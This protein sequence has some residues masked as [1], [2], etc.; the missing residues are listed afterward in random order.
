[1]PYKELREEVYMGAQGR[2]VIPAKLRRLLE[3]HEGD[4]LIARSEEGHLVVEK[5]EVTRKRLKSRYSGIAKNRSL[6]QE[7]IK[8]RREDAKRDS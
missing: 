5:K 4:T 6:A 7:L 1:M 2:L 8:E 3:L